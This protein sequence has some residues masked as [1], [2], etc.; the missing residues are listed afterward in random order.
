MELDNGS[1]MVPDGWLMLPQCK[2]MI[3]LMVRNISCMFLIGEAKRRSLT[4][5]L[6]VKEQH[7]STLKQKSRKISRQ[8]LNKGANLDLLGTETNSAWE[9]RAIL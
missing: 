9:C 2:R 4:E 3:G 5:G 6:Y 1:L 7:N 8:T